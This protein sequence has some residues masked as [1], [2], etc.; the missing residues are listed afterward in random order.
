MLRPSAD[1]RN[2]TSSGQN[3]DG[4]AISFQPFDITSFI[5][6]LVPGTN[7]LAIHGLNQGLTSSD[8]LFVP[9]I[10]A[11]GGCRSSTRPR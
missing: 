1:V 9:E 2:S 7:V 8:L 5:D 6:E 10:S 11:S 4:A 3:G